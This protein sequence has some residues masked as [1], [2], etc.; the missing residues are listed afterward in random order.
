MSLLDAA[1]WWIATRHPA[2]YPFL[3]ACA[4]VAGFLVGRGG[5]A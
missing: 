5:R 4:F 1:A 2:F 3:L